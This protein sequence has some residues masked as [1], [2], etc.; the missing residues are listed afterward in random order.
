MI[1][2]AQCA[3][4]RK[5]LIWTRPRLADAAGTSVN[6]VRNLELGLHELRPSSAAA[7]TRALQRAGVIFFVDQH[8][9]PSVRLPRKGS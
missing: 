4:A 5:L 2:A 8:D 3:A 6:T 1:T 9:G 7:I